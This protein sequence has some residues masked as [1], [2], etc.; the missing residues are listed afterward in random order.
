M[1]EVS[2]PAKAALSALAADPVR[3]VK[4]LIVGGVGSGKST[5]L[6]AIRDVLRSAGLAVLTSVPSDPRPPAVVVVDDAHLLTDTQLRSLAELAADPVATVVATTEPRTH[7]P[8]LT[9]LDMAVERE[10]P[11]VTLGPWSRTEVGRRLA[12][13][14][15]ATLDTLMRATAGL[16]FLVQAAGAAGWLPEAITSAARGAL[17]ERLRRLDD[18]A[19][20][21]LLIMSL[22]PGLG[23]ADVAATLGIGAEQAAVL[24]DGCYATG[25]LDPTQPRGFTESVHG[26]AAAL[27]GA[28][29]HHEIYSALLR[30]QSENGTLSTDLALALAEHGLRDAQLAAALEVRAGDTRHPGEAARM[31]RA[32][33]RSGDGSAALGLRLG[34]ASAL[35]GDCAGAAARADAVLDT[36]DPAHRATAVRIAASVA[37]HDGNTGQ[38]AELF[39][40][41]AK[42]PDQRPDPA[43]GSA[44][45]IVL[46][47][48]GQLDAAREMAASHG[49]GPPTLSARTTRSLAEGL[50]LTLDQPYAV[51]A[52]RLG[53]A[54]GPDVPGSGAMPDSAPAL[55]TLAALHAG[56]AVRARSVIGRAAV[57]AD[58]DAMFGHRHRLLQAWVRMQDGQLSA[59]AVDAAA[60]ATADLHRRDAFWLAALQAAIARRAGDSGALQRHWFTGLDVIAEYSIDLF[61]LLP[62]GELW[63]CA[64]R[65][66]QTDRLSFALEQAFGLLTA[67]GDPPAWSLPLHWAGVHAAILTSSPESMAPHGQALAAAAESSRFAAALA[68]AGRAWLRVLARQ[69]DVDEVAAAARGLA[70][71]GLTW[72]GTRLTGQAA[73]QAPDSRASAAMLQLAR[74]LKLTADVPTRPHDPE[75]TESRPTTRAATH[76]SPLSDREREVAE[77]LLLGMPYRDIGTQLFISSKTVEHHVA[78]M[79]R[80]LGAESR[81]EVLSMLRAILAPEA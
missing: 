61:S 48:A 15:P 30:T 79:R 4:L 54:V 50:L 28:A 69:V 36:D 31:L 40:W 60:V 80:R 19:L 72:D 22:S 11:R 27:T 68:T 9:E 46:L 17:T 67:L 20:A 81:S 1:T 78:R 51:A 71:F 6:A 2:P 5:A 25:L 56:D 33:L 34:D 75:P 8:A 74:D 65:L 24:V 29:R 32:A 43:V 64:A 70:D 52:A 38:A 62:L 13:G 41:L 35:S 42:C 58:D 59:A 16:P 73:L 77:L 63:V 76:R 37:T 39:G 44:G 55:V 21:T 45:A 18:S 57:T 10:N 26:A 3:P 66:R 53:Q 49:A 14:D 7:N 47:A 12:V 23:P